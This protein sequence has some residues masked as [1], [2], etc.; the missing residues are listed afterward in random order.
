MRFGFV[1]IL[2]VFVA[3]YSQASEDGLTCNTMER[4]NGTVVSYN[5]CTALRDFETYQCNTPKLADGKKCMK[6]EQTK[7]HSR[8]YPCVP[9]YWN[10]GNG[11]SEI[12]EVSS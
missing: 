2:L 12:F 9:R 11:I 8:F 1:S 7:A 5:T 4:K 10:V 6:D 3:K